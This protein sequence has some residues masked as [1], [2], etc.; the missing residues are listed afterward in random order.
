MLAAYLK[1]IV[2]KLLIFER[3]VFFSE[4]YSAKMVRYFEESEF[5][6]IFRCT[7][8]SHIIEISC[9]RAKFRLAFCS[10]DN[11]IS[12]KISFG[13]AKFRATVHLGSD[14]SWNIS[15]VGV[16]IELN[17]LRRTI[18]KRSSVH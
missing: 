12:L 6:S 14:I 4:V 2:G 11:E 10:T 8:C 1:F 7:Y 17:V 18:F 16:E 15:F 5:S 9:Q 13:K 3:K